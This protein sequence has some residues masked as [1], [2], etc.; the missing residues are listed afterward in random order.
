MSYMNNNQQPKALSPEEW[1]ELSAMDE[2]QQAWGL[3]DPD[4]A[5]ELENMTYAVKFDFQSGCPGYCGDLYI[6]QGDALTG[7]PPFVFRRN[8]EG[9]LMFAT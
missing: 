7:E 5:A 1:R 8:A 2:V 9:K 4:L 6:L 3:S